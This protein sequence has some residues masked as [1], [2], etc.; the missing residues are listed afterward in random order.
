MVYRIYTSGLVYV[1]YIYTYTAHLHIAV[2]QV[3]ELEG[4]IQELLAKIR[5]L[6]RTNSSLQ[7]K[8][9]FLEPSQA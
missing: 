6:E 8:V 4:E 9:S 2:V 5:H 7:N 1:G 3:R